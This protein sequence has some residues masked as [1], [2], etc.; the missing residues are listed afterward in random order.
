M[1]RN[2]TIIG[3]SFSVTCLG[4]D[5]LA[6]LIS[7]LMLTILSYK[8]LDL[9]HPVFALIMQEVLIMTMAFFFS[10][11]TFV[12]CIEDCFSLWSQVYELIFVGTCLF[13]QVTWMTITLIR[14]LMI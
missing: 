6:C 4:L 3:D 2:E 12:I 13:H 8:T 7:S 11:S 10:V 5:Q 14:L 1:A 9:R